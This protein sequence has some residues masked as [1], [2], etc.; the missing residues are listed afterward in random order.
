MMMTAGYFRPLP[1]LPKPFWR[2]PVSY[3]N[4]SAWALQ[5]SLRLQTTIVPPKEK[6]PNFKCMVCI[7]R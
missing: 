2:Y 7:A 1:D 3:I 5:V 4:Y 6:S